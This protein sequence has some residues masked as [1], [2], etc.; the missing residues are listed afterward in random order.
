MRSGPPPSCPKLS[1]STLAHFD[2]YLKVF[3]FHQRGN[4]FDPHLKRISP[5][6][7]EFYH[8]RWGSNKF[9]STYYKL[10]KIFSIRLPS[11]EA[12]KTSG[13]TFRSHF[14]IVRGL[15]ISKSQQDKV[16]NFT[17]KMGK[18]IILYFG[19]K[20]AEIQYETFFRKSC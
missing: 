9:P 1:P 16:L 20:L 10:E 13:Y 4:L 5:R 17:K 11:S 12:W 3:K 14:K 7:P 19:K 15:H 18:N 6:V 2:H 8:L